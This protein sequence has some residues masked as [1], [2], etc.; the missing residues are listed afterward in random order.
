MEL[1]T[2]RN[3]SY[4]TISLIHKKHWKVFTLCQTLTLITFFFALPP[5]MG[6]IITKLTKKDNTIFILTIIILG[7]LGPQD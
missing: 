6:L 1:A 4:P 5:P 2:P 7:P 3:L